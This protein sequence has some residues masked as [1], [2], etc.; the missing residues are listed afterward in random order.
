VY[1]SVAEPEP[2]QN[3]LFFLSLHFISHKEVVG[4]EAAKFFR[5]GAG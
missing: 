1:G 3:V 2:H 4:A 5:P